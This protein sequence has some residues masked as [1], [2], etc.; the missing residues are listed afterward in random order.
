MKQSLS[1]S[2]HGNFYMVD[3]QLGSN[4]NARCRH[5][6]SSCA[7]LHQVAELDIDEVVRLIKEMIAHR[8]QHFPSRADEPIQCYVCGLGEP[9]EPE[10]NLPKL[11]DLLRKTEDLNVNVA[12]FSNGVYW[13]DELN[14]CLG[15]GGAYRFRFNLR[16]T[17][18]QKLQNPWASAKPQL[19][20][21]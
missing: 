12:M 3:M 8:N 20:I 15:G 7:E 18:T 21:N 10:E 17:T 1:D 6:D 4:C 19:L 16:P 2:W 5:C 14:K 13:D 9:T 11:K